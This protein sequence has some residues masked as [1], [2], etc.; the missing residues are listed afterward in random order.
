MATKACTV[1]NIQHGFIEA[2][3][4]DAENF[5]YPVFDKIIGTCRWNPS[6]EEYKNTENNMNTII[7]ES[8]EF[9]HISEEVYDRLNIVRD[10][11]STGCEVL[12]D[13]TISQES[14]QGTKCLMHK[15]QLY[16]QK[17]CLSQNQRIKT[18]RKELAKHKHQEKISRNDAI[19]GS[20]CK[21]SDAEIGTVNE[22]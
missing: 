1:K 18:E 19:V 13:A 14:Y 20:L 2:G 9:G 7:H 22:E 10:R 5:W 15:H 17:E 16:L 4:I 21:I 8:C 6:V 12:R 3:I 11:D